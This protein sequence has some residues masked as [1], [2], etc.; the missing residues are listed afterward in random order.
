MS[1]SDPTAPFAFRIDHGISQAACSTPQYRD[2]LEAISLSRDSV[3]N[4]I[5]LFKKESVRDYWTYNTGSLS[6]GDRFG[7]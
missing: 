2:A 1:G 3:L 4:R 6:L 7:G 5:G